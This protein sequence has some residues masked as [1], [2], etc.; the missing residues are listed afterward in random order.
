MRLPPGSHTL[1]PD[2]ASIL[3][4]TYRQG[5]ASKAGHDLVM[6]VTRWEGTFTIGAD[7]TQSTVVLTAD[8]RSLEVRE[9]VHGV[10]PLSDKDRA[11][12][13]KNTEDKV[14]RGAPI[15]FRSSRLVPSEDG[16]RVAVTGDLEIAGETRPISFELIVD[17]DGGIEGSVA[18]T[19]SD[20]GIKPY[21]ALM[22]A[23]KVRD[24]L[25]VVFAAQ[26]PVR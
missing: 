7:A 17:P 2:N 5:V 15:T 25:D 22:G 4:K 19:Q 6:E 26:P 12:I 21:S 18:V 14:L 16:H 13:K 10:K 20:W 11:D 9:G 1:G 23:L 8:S 3:L 24:A